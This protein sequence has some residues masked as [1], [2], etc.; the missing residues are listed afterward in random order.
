M[1]PKSKR[2]K[3]KGEKKKK[4][5][6]VLPVAIDITVNLPD[7]SDVILKG[8][9]TDRIIDVRRLLCVHT[10]T[11]AITN[12]SLSHETRDGHLKDGAD[13]VTLKPYTLT[14]VEGEYDEDSALVH[15]RRLLDIVA[16]TASFGSPP[17]PPPPPSPKDADATKEPSNSS[18]KPAAA[19]S[20]G[21]RRM[22]S[23]PP[24]PKES[25]AK[26][27]NAAS[28][29][30]DAVS[31][32]LE[33]EMSGACPRLGAFYEFFSLANL[34]PPLHFIKRVT[35]PRQE[36]Q[37]S[38]DHLFFL[39]AKLCNGK[40]F[41]VEARRK[42]FFSFGKQR[43]LCHNLVDLLRHLSRAF[44]NAYEDLM[45]AF[46]ERNK[47]GNFPYGYRANT[48][49]VPPIAAQ[50]PST[51]PPLPAEDETWGGNGGGWGRNGKSD[52]LPWAD[53]FMYLT[54]MP[55]KTAEER[56]IRDRRAFLL[57]SLFVDVAMFRTIAAIRHVMESTDASTA[58]KID[59]VLHS[60]TVGN[61][62]ITV[63]RD[64]SDASCKLDTKIDGSRATGVDSKH[65]GERNLLKGIT[66]DENTAAHDVDS[67]GIVNIRY[68]GYVAVAKVNNYEKTIVASSIKPADIMDQPEGGAHALNINSLRMLINE[69]NA[70]GEKKLPTQSHRQEELT[71]A[72]TYAEN[73]LKG[74]LQNLEEEETD[75]QSFMR[76][77][78]GA[79]WVQHL[80]D[81]KKSDKDKKQGDGKEKKKM[82]DKAVKE[83]KIEGL[84]KPLK[85]LKHPNNAVDASG[86]GSSSG[87]KSLTDATSS[88]ENQKVNSSSVESPQGDCITSESEILL[89][90][91]LLDSAF[92]RLKDSE[93]GLHQKSPSELIEMALKF[94]DEVALPKLVADFGSLELSP[95]DGRTL[96]DF[97]HTRG[98]Q[99]RS[100]GRVVKLSEKLSHV[101]SLCVHEMIVRAFKHI[102]R[103]VIAATSD[104]RQLALTIPAVLNLLLGVP[105]SEFSGSSPAVHP[106]VWRWLV[107]FLKKRYQYDLTEQH[108]VDVR[109]YAILRGL[110]HKV[111]IELAP[112]DFVMD[113][114]F[115]F[116]KQDII[117]LVPVH[118]QVACS[119]ADGRQ[120]L[121]S[122]KTA[123]DK[124]KLE[125]AV[126]YGTK[127]LAKLIMVCGP[128][129]RMTAGAYSLLAVVLYHTGDF[130][131]A[132]IY[133]QKALDINERELGL[134]HPDTMKSYG[135]LA[136][137]YYRLQ[138]TE[139]A[140][141]Y[142]KRALYL[143]HLTC[144]PSHPNTAATYINVAMMEE[145]LGNVHVALRYLHKALKCNQRLLGPDHIQTA[146]SYHAIA[147]ALSLMEA[148]SLSVQH[149][150]TTLQILRAKL[151]PDDLRT[152]DAAAWLE[153]FESKVIEQQEAARNGTRKPDASIASKGHLSVSD[154][155]DYINPNK[156]NRGR[157]SES[158]KRRYSSI[159]VLSHSSENLNIESP[160]ISPRDSAIAITDEEKRIRG[161]LQ[162][163]SAKIMD[164]PETEVKESPLSVEASPPS[165]Q[166][167]E[168]AEVN[169]SSPE[170]VFDEEQDDGWQPVQRPKTA[171]VL[172][173]QIKHYRPAIRR[174]S[175]P[176]NH[177]PTDASQYKPRN[178]YSNNRYYFLKKKTIVPAAYADPQQHTK[179][180]TSSS[181]F[182]RKIYKAMTYRIKPGTASS[183]VQDTSRLT[184][185]MGGKEESQIA[186]SHVHNRSADLKGSEPHGPWVESTGNPPSYKDVALARPGT[187]AKTQIQKRKD[188]VLQ[189]SLGQI[190]AQEMK[191]SL[192]DTVQVDQ[193]SVS[194][195]TN[196]SKEVNIVPT[197]M[198]HSEQREES[199]RE[200]EI[201]DTGKD[202]LPDKLT[203]NTEKPSGGGPADI[204]T[205]TTLL[206]NNKDQEPT[207]SDNFGAAT[208][209]SD[210]TVPTEAENSGKSGIQFLEESLPTNS[211][212]I[213]VSAHTTSMQ[214]GVGGVESKKSKPDMLLSNID[215]REMSNKKLSAAA[216]P[217]NPSPP[218]ILS[219]LAVSVGLPPPG[220]VPGVGPWP[221]NVSMHPGHSNM[222]PNGP[223]LCTSPHHL[224]PPAPRS[225]NLLHH[226]PFL[227]PPYSQ[228]Q[229]AP[230]STFPMNTTIFRPNH[231]G[232]QPYMSPAA[233]EFV[234]GPAWSN[235]HPVAYTPSPHVA[236]TISQ[237]LAD[238]HVLSDAAVVSIGPLLDSNMVAV[239]EEVEVPVEVC[240]GNLI[241]NK[242]LGE[243]HDKE[244][245]DAVNA[246]LNPD[247]PGDSIFDIGGTKLGGSMKNEDEGSFRIFVKGKGR[248]KQTLRIPIS[249]L[250][251][252]YSSRSFKLDFNR[253][254]REN[255]IFMP[256]GVSFAEVVSSGN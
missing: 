169:I 11:C 166:L 211:E 33:A 20:S 35:Q 240:S 51:F 233:S 218:A 212:P 125:D 184:E 180:Q 9:S 137:F 244:L 183:E 87:N 62:S 63:T 98:L 158:G 29:K 72:Q 216:P 114:A 23:P 182:G 76:W 118:K 196:N 122:S 53:E 177:A 245:K 133:Q 225:P 108:Y 157:D 86:K 189:P 19:A 155:L 209:F 176:E 2:G 250:N 10:A 18:S 185:Q 239:R 103:S 119:S 106:L 247:K 195:S 151:G 75:K 174:T 132:T 50:S 69:A 49:L 219:P 156:E 58:I 179:V 52:M 88:G 159:K 78:L 21:G 32:E 152:Q 171:A 45:K 116:Y 172:G 127:A 163:D 77:E 105:E 232:W 170:E 37:P 15:V 117:S 139:L 199:H 223:P 112:R 57:H 215:I 234:P 202:S 187:I 214:G 205:D 143:L 7:Q 102:V 161:P 109:K 190:I 91:V 241:S 252:T 168:R 144:G 193:R 38:D 138:H 194:S 146:A 131:Q 140:L 120:L 100:L 1:A 217:F 60:E 188:D 251:K 242:F 126:N 243:E 164:I 55:C 213:T 142:V 134:D 92:T 249:L 255:D 97:M 178:S 115:P 28:A 81:L 130:N 226:V 27:A 220:A 235:N 107:A 129:H 64:S 181:R 24:L 84:G 40:F 191:D 42:G 66:A 230:S 73:L 85:A 74:S 79:C 56:E 4:D 203:S 22:G 104:M 192:V 89:K 46:L 145:G 153:Y 31:A 128:Y 110:C 61:F 14:L 36:E 99:M 41:I 154:L 222:V 80:Q 136:V 93:T 186:Y 25:A 253:V 96:T 173:K 149:E 48:W 68:C 197:E 206:S 90:D 44:N 238:T 175:D 65:L 71:A 3:A 47:F 6:K 198:Q 237:S 227:Y 94:Y 200:H 236:D 141:K 8:I 124:G 82:V 231:Y 160:D 101:Q 201:D 123:L 16:C 43:V 95:V 111:G 254:V 256:S 26:D 150:Q 30:E 147:I 229:M 221:M 121:E 248:R 83:T 135:D 167:V 210:S 70:T 34:S 67:L 204:K 148:Y 113:S 208:E 228:P 17:P 13:V 12:Y 162:D 224:Y 54:S 5:E 39:E 59:E 207:S 165:E 246:A